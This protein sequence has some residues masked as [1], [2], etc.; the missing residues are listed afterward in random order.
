[1]SE[2]VKLTQ[3]QAAA[4]ETFLRDNGND[5][6]HLVDWHNANKVIYLVE[7]D[8]QPLMTLKASAL[9]TALFIGYELEQPKFQEG[10]KVVRV[11]GKKFNMVNAVEIIE[12]AHKNH[13]VLSNSMKYSPD[14]VRHATPE[15]IY[16]LYELDRDDI[17]KFHAGD[18][19]ISSDFGYPYKIDTF[20][21]IGHT[22]SSEDAFEAWHRGN[23]KGIYPAESFKPFDK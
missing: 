2:Q 21:N 5:K 15:E 18:I 22:L 20:T 12:S 6:L 4:I 19:I 3:E 1:M 10:D 23:I 16:W 13:L 9:A 17:A 11:D 7:T 14:F 8:Y